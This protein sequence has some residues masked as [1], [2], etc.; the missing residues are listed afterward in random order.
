MISMALGPGP[1]LDMDPMALGPGPHLD[2]KLKM[3]LGPGPHLDMNRRRS[4]L[5]SALR[6]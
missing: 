2:M 3:A 6:G 1:H 5:V 4:L